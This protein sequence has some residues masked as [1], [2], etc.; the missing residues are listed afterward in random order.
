MKIAVRDALELAAL[1]LAVAT[2][3][4]ATHL[5]WPGLL[6]TAVALGYLSHAWAWEEEITIPRPALRRPAWLRRRRAAE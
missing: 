5:L 2:V 4:L 6:T 3:V 1:V